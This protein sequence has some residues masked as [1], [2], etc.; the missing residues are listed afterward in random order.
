MTTITYLA[1]YSIISKLSTEDLGKPYPKA[2]NMTKWNLNAELTTWN[3]LAI[4][5]TN[6]ILIKEK[7]AKKLN[8]P[9][10]F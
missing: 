3:R 1:L 4:I 10:V 6:L 5:I 7:N 2:Y 9:P 8:R